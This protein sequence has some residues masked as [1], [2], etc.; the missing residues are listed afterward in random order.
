MTQRT[1]HGPRTKG[2][3]VGFPVRAHVRVVG[4]VPSGGHVRA[5]RQWC[6]SPALSPS[7]PL[8][9]KINKKNLLKKDNKYL[10]GDRGWYWL[11]TD[12]RCQPIPGR[13]QVHRTTQTLSQG[14]HRK[15]WKQE[16]A[17]LRV[18]GVENGEAR[19]VSLPPLL[20]VEFLTLAYLAFLP[21]TSHLRFPL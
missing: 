20:L 19:T 7:Q 14:S 5:T 3:L 9:L 18:G 15:E 11:S 6:F 13:L 21:Q 16:G 17:A 8:S 1:E 10:K 4:Q 2:S 12:G